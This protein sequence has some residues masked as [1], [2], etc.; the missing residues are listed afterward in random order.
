MQIQ[1]LTEE[2]ILKVK[3]I[4]SLMILVTIEVGKL[5]SSGF[6]AILLKIIQ[7]LDSLLMDLESKIR[8]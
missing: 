8:N 6:S 5:R 4:R 1:Y 7:K 3:I 2:I